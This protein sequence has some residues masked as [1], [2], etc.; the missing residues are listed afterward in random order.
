M[1]FIPY[2]NK[3]VFEPLKKDSIIA[4]DKDS[5][6]E[7]G[8]VISIGRDVDFV[9]EGDTIFFLSYGAEETPEYEGKKYWTVAAESAFLMGKI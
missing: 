8:T 6:I 4:N 3:I 5:A 1:T 7:A 2:Y 9:K